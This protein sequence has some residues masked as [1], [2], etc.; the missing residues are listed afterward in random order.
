MTQQLATRVAAV[1]VTLALAGCGGSAPSTSP[2]PTLE[3]TAVPT[4]APTPTIAPSVAVTFPPL[5]GVTGRMVF[6]ATAPTAT[7]ADL[8]VMNADGSGVTKLAG[9]VGGNE[10]AWSP[11]ASLI[12]FVRGDGIWVMHADGSGAAQVHRTVGLVSEWP[13]WS[14]DGKQIAFVELPTC[15]PCSIGMTWA[16]NVM[17]ADGT[18]VRHVADAANDDRPAWS[19]DGQSLAFDGGWND[20]PDASNGLQTIR[21]DGTGQHQLTDGPDMSPAWSPDGRL[22]FLRGASTMED[23]TIIF[24]LFIARTDGSGAQAVPLTFLPQPSLAWSSDGHWLAMAA[25]SQL[26]IQQI[27]QW[28]I[29]VTQ[30]DGNGAQKVT[31][32]PNLAEGAPSW[33]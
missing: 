8:Y 28:E 18:G 5:G 2:V 16:V 24:S 31:N 7:S 32:T 20:P 21:L 29:F 9:G 19:P 6:A 10:P 3:P 22:A 25:A 15:S 4:V 27:G 1:L 13:A 14:P 33:H 11:D 17:N 23:G 30:P 12:A 26:P